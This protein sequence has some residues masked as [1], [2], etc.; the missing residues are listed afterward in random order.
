MITNYMLLKVSSYYG[1]LS[2]SSITNPVA[3]G[4]MINLPLLYASMFA[5]YP[6]RSREEVRTHFIC[7]DLS[8]ILS[9]KAGTVQHYR[10]RPQFLSY[11]EKAFHLMDLKLCQCS[12]VS[13]GSVDAIISRC[14]SNY[15]YNHNQK[16]LFDTRNSVIPVLKTSK[17][18]LLII[19]I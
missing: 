7:F 15:C 10:E 11:H 8:N 5:A 13:F 19:Q 1:L 4:N 2:T 3:T 14:S 16:I 18:C 17:Y 9:L 12:Q 6:A